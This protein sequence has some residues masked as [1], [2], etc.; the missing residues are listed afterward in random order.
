MRTTLTLDD[1][2]AAIIERERAE[3]GETLR[4]VANRLIR[5]GHRPGRQR[6]GT[7]VLPLLSGGPC[8]EIADISAVLAEE[9]DEHLRDTG[10]L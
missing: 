10:Q 4:Q 1:D 5:Q 7:V 3:T 8:V 9:E 6:R 2:V